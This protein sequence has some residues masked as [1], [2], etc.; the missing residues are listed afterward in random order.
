MC[1]CN[2]IYQYYHMEVHAE[3]VLYLHAEKHACNIVA[4]VSVWKMLASQN[5]C[6]IH[7]TVY[8]IN[9]IVYN[10]HYMMFTEHSSVMLV[11]D[12]EQ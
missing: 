8:I 4:C 1:V 5:V 11:G 2:E 10:I 7:C 9:S 6:F 12:W 3:V